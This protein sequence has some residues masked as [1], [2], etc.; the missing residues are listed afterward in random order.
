[1]N[2]ILII[3]DLHFK[4]N[5][6]LITDII[7]RDIINIIINNNP[8]FIVILGDTFNDHNKLE[9]DTF[10]R[11]SKFLDNITLTGKII[12]LLIGNHDRKDNKVYMNDEHF[13]YEHKKNPLIKVIDKT[14][15]FNIKDKKIC[16]VPYIP[17][18][19]LFDS[20][21]E[22]NIEPS[23]MD[24][25]FGH[26][27]IHGSK[28]EKLAKQEWPEW[29]D[30]YKLMVSGHVHD[31]EI[32]KDNFI[33]VGT[34]YQSNFGECENKGVYL[35]NLDDYS[36]KL[37]KLTVP[38]KKKITLHYTELERFTIDPNIELKINITGSKTAAR[39]L[40]KRNDMVLKYSGIKISYIGEEDKFETLS[41]PQITKNSNFYDHL[42]ESIMS[43]Q[44]LIDIFKEEFVDQNGILNL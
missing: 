43:N 11:V 5:N 25:F 44:T 34:P 9:L 12:Y 6:K 18:E 32:V 36:L 2:H 37:I 29:P 31:K 35:M 13:F 38:I 40:M 21:K 39:E 8:E 23:E 41:L 19:K 33:Y 15:Y 7:E 27:D 1:M 17:P 14:T 26:I 30:N 22:T 20:F 28:T 24:L 10:I 16:F 4:K 3:G 42:I